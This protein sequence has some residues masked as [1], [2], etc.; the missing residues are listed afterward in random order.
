MVGALGV[1]AARYGDLSVRAFEVNHWG[2][3]Y[4]SDNWR[5]NGYIVESGRYRVLLA[6]DTALTDEFRALRSSRPFDLAIMPIGAYNPR[7][8]NHCSPEQAGRMGNDAGAERF[9]PVHHRTFPLGQEP[10]DEPIAR[11]YEVAGGQMER[12]VAGRIGGQ[13]RII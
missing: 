10:V 3:R 8:H 6:G 4:G 5:G 7:I 12:I 11:F 13:T 9:L 1:Y 2:A